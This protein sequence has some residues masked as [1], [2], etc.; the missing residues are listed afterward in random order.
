MDQDQQR[1]QHQH[2]FQLLEGQGSPPS[3]PREQRRALLWRRR[4]KLE[5]EVQGLFVRTATLVQEWQHLHGQKMALGDEVSK[6][7]SHIVLAAFVG[8]QQQ[9]SAWQHSLE[10]DRIALEEIRIQQAMLRCS[11]DIAALQAQINRLDFGLALLS[12]HNRS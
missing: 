8:I 2:L 10:R 1:P 11:M 9:P 4:M 12:F 7:A 5:F 6:V 3:N